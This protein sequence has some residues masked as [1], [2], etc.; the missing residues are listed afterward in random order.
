MLILS[1][2]PGQAVVIGENVEITVVEVRGDMVRLGIQ[3]PR[4]VSVHRKEVYLQIAEANKQA[5]ETDLAAVAR[6][7]QIQPPGK[8][9]TTQPGVYIVT[10]RTA[11]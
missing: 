7:A 4:S 11:A 8:P 3:A 6:A 1:R 9:A 10:K 2:K 5:T